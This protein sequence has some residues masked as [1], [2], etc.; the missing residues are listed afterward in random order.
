MRAHP[1]YS[2][3]AAGARIRFETESALLR[4]EWKWDTRNQRGEPV[5]SGLYLYA[6]YD[7]RDNVIMK[8]KLMIVR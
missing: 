5:A 8:G 3:K 6:V 2:T 1:I 7:P 4:P